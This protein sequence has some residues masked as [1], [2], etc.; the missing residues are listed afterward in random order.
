MIT[1]TDRQLIQWR[2]KVMSNSAMYQLIIWWLIMLVSGFEGTKRMRSWSVCLYK[3]FKTTSNATR[4]ICSDSIDYHYKYMHVHVCSFVILHM[5]CALALGSIDRL[6]SLSRTL[7][8]E[9]AIPTPFAGFYLQEEP[10]PLATWNIM[11]GDP[12]HNLKTRQTT[13]I[14][15]FGYNIIQRNINNKASWIDC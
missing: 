12:T 15:V 13:T 9:Q 11:E 10:V 1:T 2:N 3:E 5:V 6:T 4:N 7:T 14:I 8:G